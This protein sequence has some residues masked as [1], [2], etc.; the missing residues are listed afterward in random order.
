VVRIPGTSSEI[1]EL[2]V[3]TN[4]ILKV[5]QDISTVASP[6]VR[7]AVAR[8]K[9]HRQKF[10]EIALLALEKRNPSRAANLDL[11]RPLISPDEEAP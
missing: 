5:L 11:Q 3:S 7:D 8:Y 6:E 9:N 1:R 4:A 10:M 2:K